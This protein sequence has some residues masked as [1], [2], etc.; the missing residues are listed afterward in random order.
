MFAR[1]T[2]VKAVNQSEVVTVSLLKTSSVYQGNVVYLVPSLCLLQQNNLGW[3]WDPNALP[4]Q[5][6]I[7]G[8]WDL[9]ADITS[10]IANEHF[11]A[12]TR[13]RSAHPRLQVHLYNIGK[14]LVKHYVSIHCLQAQTMHDA[15]MHAW[16]GTESGSKEARHVCISHRHGCKLL[17][18]FRQMALVA[19]V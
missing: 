11:S 19:L 2:C 5:G 7:K 6:N 9:A 14:A 18:K 16:V 15:Y 8:L 4:E 1:C 10:H 17:T 3:A 13:A 12:D